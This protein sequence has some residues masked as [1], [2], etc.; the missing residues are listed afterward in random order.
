MFNLTLSRESTIAC[1]AGG[2][3]DPCTQCESEKRKVTSSAATSALRDAGVGAAGRA[4]RAT[5]STESACERAGQVP[6]GLT[7]IHTVK[8][9]RRENQ[10]QAEKFIP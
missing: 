8:V 2:R 6:D 10:Y 7:V 4:A 3:G 1:A 5:E 9:A